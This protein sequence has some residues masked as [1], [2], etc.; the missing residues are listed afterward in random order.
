MHVN[1][2]VDDPRCSAAD[3]GQIISLDA[4]LTARLLK[5]ANSSFYSFPSRIETVSRAI[6][7]LG[8]RE[9]RDLIMATTAVDVFSGLPNELVSMET[10]W[11]HSLRC[12]VIARTLAIHLREPNIERYFV[13][14]LLH[15][16]GYLIIYS[17]IPEL[18]R[19]TLQHC[20]E[21]SE[22]VYI[23][24]QEI[25]GFDHASVGAELLRRWDL[26]PAQVEAVAFH[27]TPSLARQHP[28]EAAVIHVANYLA[29]TML[30]N[31]NGDIELADLDPEALQ[32]LNL[33]RES[34]PELMQQAEQQFKRAL[35][36]IIR[37]QAA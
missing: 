5:I 31:I 16:I 23:V 9:L 22:I 7:I 14:G 12:A 4:G 34:F 30:A 29:N 18:G 24:E 27:H 15:D 33:R 26:P 10:F 25:I 28:K 20:A 19:Q 32:R 3:I 1:A 36:V 6:T 21:N 13:A 17:Q 37:P 11:R 35:D 8:T 2:M